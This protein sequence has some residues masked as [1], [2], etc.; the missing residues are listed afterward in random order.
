MRRLPYY[1]ICLWAVC[2]LIGCTGNGY[3]P[4]LQAIDSLMNDSPDSALSMLERMKSEVPEWSKAQRMRYH[5]LTMKARN[6]A[7]IDF[8]SDSLA[9][10]VVE[11]YDNHGTTHL[12]LLVLTSSV[13]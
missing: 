9:K 1:I 2:V 13:Q 8:T 12:M 10:D 6:K 3:T 4:A 7:Y 11:Y 5:L